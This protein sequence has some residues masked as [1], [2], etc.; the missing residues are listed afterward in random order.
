[1][2]SQ[3]LLFDS[4]TLNPKSGLILNDFFK[5][6]KTRKETELLSP[7]KKIIYQQQPPKGDF[8]RQ[9]KFLNTSNFQ[10]KKNAWILKTPYNIKK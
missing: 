10:D 1:M 3:P 6:H 4:R 2:E 5:V 8:E 9:S 7:K